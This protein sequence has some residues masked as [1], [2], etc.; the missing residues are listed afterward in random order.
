[1]CNKTTVG[2]PLVLWDLG[3]VMSFLWALVSHLNNGCVDSRL[4][5]LFQI[6]QLAFCMAFCMAQGK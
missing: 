3:R 5:Q 6:Q 1:M 2:P 4:V